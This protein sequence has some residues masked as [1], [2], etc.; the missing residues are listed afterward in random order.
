MN[1]AL[2]TELL[3]KRP[4]VAAEGGPLIYPFFKG[5]W[6]YQKHRDTT[7]QDTEVRARCAPDALP[8]ALLG[9]L[10][11]LFPKALSIRRGFV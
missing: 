11:I 3:Q 10:R 5:S 6:K 7:I 4:S 9:M 1:L 8:F 2:Q